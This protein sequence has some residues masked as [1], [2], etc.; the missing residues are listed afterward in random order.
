MK[1]ISDIGEFGFIDKIAAKY[2]LQNKKSLGIG[3]DCSVV[4]IDENQSRLVTTDML[5]ENVHFLRDKISADTLGYK[6]LAVN[7]SDIAAMGGVPENIY[8]SLGLPGDIPVAW[9]EDFY[10]GLN[11][12][13]EKFQAQLMGGDTTSSRQNIIINILVSGRIETKNIKYRKG[14][15][16][17][18]II[19]VN[20]KLGDSAAGL[21]ILLNN[22]ETDKNLNNL[23]QA[24][25]KPEPK[26]IEGNFLSRS[27]AVN[28]M[29]DVSDGIG[30]DIRHI[31]ER[32]GI[33]ARIDLDSLPVSNNLKSAANK[34]NWNAIDLA[35]NGGEDY[36]LL[37]TVDPAGFDEL[38]RNYE[39]KFSSSITKIG[40]IQEK[41]YGLRY[42]YKDEEQQFRG[43]GFDHFKNV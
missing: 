40:V 38:K 31:M 2:S 1:T 14:A 8:I 10:A 35:V 6:S 36:C 4:S 12:L 39:T 32:S 37:F 25:N 22:I 26:I 16:P 17:N 29:L 11:T 3:D 18:D 9:L 30:S 7:F 33:G 21:K 19:C 43:E 28:A 20:D 34:Y 42:F 41:D 24:H 5:I 13:A 27:S 15:N 23:I